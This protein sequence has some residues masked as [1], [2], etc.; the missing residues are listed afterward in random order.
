MWL[1]S[2]ELSHNEVDCTVPM[3]T[4]AARV[5]NSNNVYHTFCTKTLS[6]H[7]AAMFTCV[8]V[9]VHTCNCVFCEPATI[10]YDLGHWPQTGTQPIHTHVKVAMEYYCTVKIG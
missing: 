10:C 1:C 2:K 9:C 8:C 4:T 6:E 5:V 7:T 3:L